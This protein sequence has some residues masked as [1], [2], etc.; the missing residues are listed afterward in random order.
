MRPFK[1]AYNAVTNI[2]TTRKLTLNEYVKS[3]I[4]QSRPIRKDV[5]KRGMW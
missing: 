2:K 4:I 1:A 3:Q 5:T